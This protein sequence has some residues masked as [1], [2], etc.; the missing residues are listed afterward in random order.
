MGY[1]IYSQN[2]NFHRKIGEVTYK[3]LLLFTNWID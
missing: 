1:Y 2:Y 3:M